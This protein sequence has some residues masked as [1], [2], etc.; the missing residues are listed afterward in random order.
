MSRILKQ[1]AEFQLNG[2]DTP[3][4]LLENYPYHNTGFLLPTWI[5]FNVANCTSAVVSLWGHRHLRKRLPLATAQQRR[6]G[7]R[8]TRQ[9]DR[10]AAMPAAVAC[11]FSAAI[12]FIQQSQLREAVGG[13]G[14]DDWGLQSY[15]LLGWG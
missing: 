10:L 1:P 3:F 7:G 9:P 12:S 4:L 11:P 15:L 5:G 6:P 13:P 14:S 2:K 8:E